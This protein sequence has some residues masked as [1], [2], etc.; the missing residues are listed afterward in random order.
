[1]QFLQFYIKWTQNSYFTA[2]WKRKGSN[3]FKANSVRWKVSKVTSHGAVYWRRRKLTKPVEHDMNANVV[4][5]ALQKLTVHSSWW[6][7]IHRIRKK[8]FFSKHS[9]KYKSFMH[10][11]D[12]RKSKNVQSLIHEWTLVG[13]NHL[14]FLL[15]KFIISAT[16]FKRVK[17]L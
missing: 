14:F 5:C 2:A 13:R 12:L 10:S 16:S 7:F 17:L 15:C 3:T 6:R 1:M 11:G 4:T 9:V 8:W